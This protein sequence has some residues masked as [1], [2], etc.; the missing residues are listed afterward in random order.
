[1]AKIIKVKGETLG[2]WDIED[3]TLKE[4]F[5][6]KAGTGYDPVPLQQ[7]LETGDP[8]AWQALVWHLMNKKDPGSVQVTAV[9]FRYGDLDVTEEPADPP[10]D[11]V[12][13]SE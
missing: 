13:T 9:D 7:G 10:A 8:G 4:A 5:V 3:L 2:T 1:M 11:E 12:P 6:I